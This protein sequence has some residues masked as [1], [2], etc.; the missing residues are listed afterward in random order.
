MKY[1]DR[2][3]TGMVIITMFLA[4]P[5]STAQTGLA[6]NGDLPL[7][8]GHR[9]SVT[10][11]ILDGDTLI[12]VGEDGYLGLW[13]PRGRRALDR[14]QISA[15]HISGIEK[16]PGKSQIA[17]VESDGFGFYRISAWDYRQKK[18]LFGRHFPDPVSY[19]NYSAGGNFLI[20]VRAGNAGL[21]FIHPE[22]GEFLLSPENLSGNISL[23]ATGRSERS[24]LV[25]TAS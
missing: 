8:S 22:T 23:A 4:S 14:F 9:D 12:S 5:C 3:C 18:Q 25:Y 13:D 20:A 10:K 19:I 24:M 15:H 16:R 11:L 1:R 17:I 2:F 7:P 6:W 21:V